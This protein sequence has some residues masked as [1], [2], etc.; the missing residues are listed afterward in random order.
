MISFFITFPY[1]MACRANGFVRQ[2]RKYFFFEKKK[3]KTFDC[4]SAGSFSPCA[5]S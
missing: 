1:T 4:F 2:G 5:L 3:Q